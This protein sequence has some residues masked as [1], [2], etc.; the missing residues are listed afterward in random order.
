[1]LSAKKG[2]EPN[3]TFYDPTRQNN[4]KAYYFLSAKKEMNLLYK[5]LQDKII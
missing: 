4:I 2:N 3:P 5:T 1:V